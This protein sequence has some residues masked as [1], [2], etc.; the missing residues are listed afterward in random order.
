MTHYRLYGCVMD[1]RVDTQALEIS[2]VLYEED[3]GWI[4]QGLQFD[5]TAHGK[6][7]IEAAKRFDLKVGAELAISF[8][9]GDSL[10]LAGVPQAPPQFWEMFEHAEMRVEKD[11]TAMQIMNAPSI[12]R[13]VP[14]MRIAEHI[15]V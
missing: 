5:I 13:I 15:A 4:A 12:P 14:R 8:E 10:P 2:V 6:N 1:Q 7:P 9:L 11:Q 3:G